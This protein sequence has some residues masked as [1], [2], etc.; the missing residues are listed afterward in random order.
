MDEP[1]RPT[2]AIVAPGSHCD[3]Q[4]SEPEAPD[5]WREGAARGGPAGQDTV[6]E[7]H[8]VEHNELH[9]ASEDL[10]GWRETLSALV[11][12]ADD[13][14][15]RGVARAG[16]TD[17]HM[18]AK[19]ARGARRRRGRSKCEGARSASPRGVPREDAR[20]AVRGRGFHG[21]RRAAERQSGTRT[22]AVRTAGP[23]ERAVPQGAVQLDTPPEEHGAHTLAAEV[24]SGDGA[25]GEPASKLAHAPEHPLLDGSHE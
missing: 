19:D 11:H 5:G 9:R 23:A 25:V 18:N 13:V 6:S 7:T 24:H 10:R 20:D 3:S 2:D 22:G 4:P 14:E 17:G 21:V 15:G 1:R 16:G 12:A 8:E